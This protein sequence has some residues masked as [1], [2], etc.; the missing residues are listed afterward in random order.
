MI[1]GDLLL[2]H[3]R[4]GCWRSEKGGHFPPSAWI[5]LGSAIMI[6]ETWGSG[7]KQSK[8]SFVF[9]LSPLGACYV[10]FGDLDSHA[11]RMS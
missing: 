9:V 11:T 1:P 6:L 10:E 4:L 7:V 3:D 2:L 5:P 8:F